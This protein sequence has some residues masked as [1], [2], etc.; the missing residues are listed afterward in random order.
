MSESER[1][2]NHLLPSVCVCVRADLI[3]SVCWLCCRVGYFIA[4]S[5]VV[6]IILVAALLKGEEGPISTT[7]GGGGGGRGKEN[8]GLAR[9]P[10]PM[11]QVCSQLYRSN[12]W[13]M[14]YIGFTNNF[15]LAVLQYFL[16]IYCL[17]NYGFGQVQTANVFSVY[18]GVAAV[19]AFAAAKL[20]P[21]F[22]ERTILITGELVQTV[23]IAACVMLWGGCKVFGFEIPCL[24]IWGTFALAA[25]QSM[26]QAWQVP[27]LQGC[28]LYLVGSAGQGM[29]QALFMSATSVGRMLGSFWV[30][31]HSMP[32]MHH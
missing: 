11:G 27:G 10:V 6:Y 23:C 12:A 31:S 22:Y 18:G 1:T 21:R 20:S 19:T 14:Q 9:Q 15:A 7:S 24:P 4:A 16:P 8:A 17:E 13:V 29:Y 28:Y 25:L 26:G 30:V 3:R 5:S 32:C 2:V